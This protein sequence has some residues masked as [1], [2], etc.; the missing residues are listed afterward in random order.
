V[1][2]DP[3]V[4][5]E[6][7]LKPSPNPESKL[8]VLDDN[9]EVK[10]EEQEDDNLDGEGGYPDD[11][12]EP[13][14]GEYYEQESFYADDDSQGDENVVAGACQSIRDILRE[15]YLTFKKVALKTDVGYLS[16]HGEFF[17]CNVC[18]KHRKKEQSKDVHADYC[19][20]SMKYR[21]YLNVLK[22]QVLSL[23][24]PSL[25]DYTEL[26]YAGSGELFVS[27]PHHP[28]LSS[29]A[30]FP[31]NLDDATYIE[32][33]NNF[34]KKPPAKKE[35][36]QKEGQKPGSKN[37]KKQQL[38]N[39][40]VS[41]VAAATATAAALHVDVD[42]AKE[43][44]YG[45]GHSNRSSWSYEGVVAPNSPPTPP[46]EAKNKN[47][48]THLVSLQTKTSRA[49]G[50]KKD[51]SSSSSTSLEHSV[52]PGCQCDPDWLKKEK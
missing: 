19:K 24:F 17:W 37:E 16:M 28:E 52:S 40:Q 11:E 10:E 50:G 20:Q 13:P 35:K 34:E 21:D 48:K 18:R 43:S 7:N 14:E 36:Y 51:D 27:P 25:L 45:V 6:P 42:E 46:L 47:K 23:G 49:R 2:S 9:E 39:F 5:V 1:K 41:A 12:E 33:E 44:D 15:E 4:K 30:P 3:V 29:N 38:K 32:E 22:A 8:D 31:S 26:Y